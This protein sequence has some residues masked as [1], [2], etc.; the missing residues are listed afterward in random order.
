MVY[1][2]RTTIINSIKVEVNLF[3]KISINLERAEKIRGKSEIDASI[4]MRWQRRATSTMERH[5]STIR[6]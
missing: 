5:R 4:L 1:W 6:E 3:C 2:Y